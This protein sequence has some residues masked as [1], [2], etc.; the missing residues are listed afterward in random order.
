MA[1]GA[2]SADELAAAD[3]APGEL[4][5]AEELWWELKTQHLR[6]VALWE[7]IGRTD[8]QGADSNT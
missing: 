1:G 3:A 7:R 2:A 8:E 6:C 4:H 5:S